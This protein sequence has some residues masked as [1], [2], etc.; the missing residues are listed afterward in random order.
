MGCYQ[1]RGGGYGNNHTTTKY[2]RFRSRGA[3]YGRSRLS[4]GNRGAGKDLKLK[5]LPVFD[6]NS[7][8]KLLASLLFFFQPANARQPRECPAPPVTNS[9]QTRSVP[10]AP[11]SL[12]P[13]APAATLRDSSR[14]LRR[15]VADSTRRIFDLS[16]WLVE[17]PPCPQT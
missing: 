15:P 13:R 9:L 6:Q 10:G 12:F 8:W 17:N 14:A 11:P 2:T 16:S 4:L 1:D 3:T 5:P 7:R